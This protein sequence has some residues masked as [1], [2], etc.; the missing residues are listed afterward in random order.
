MP[1]LTGRVDPGNDPSYGWVNRRRARHHRN[2][3]LRCP[4]LRVCGPARTD[5]GCHR[6]VV[7]RDNRRLFAR[8]ARLRRRGSTD[9][10]APRPSQPRLLMTSGSIL[11]AA[12]MLAWSH[13]STLLELYLVFAGLGVAMALVLYEPAF[14]VITRWFQVRRNA[15]LTTLT[16]IAAFASFIFSPLTG[17]L[18]A[19][20]GWRD[21]VT[22]LAA[23]LAVL[24]IPLHAVVL[25]PAPQHDHLPAATPRGTHPPDRRAPRR[26]LAHRRRVRARLFRQ[27]R[28]RR[29]SGAAPH[30]RR[31][32]RGLRGPGR[33]VGPA[34]GAAR[35]TGRPR[36]HGAGRHVQSGGSQAVDLPRGLRPAAA[37]PLQQGLSSWP[38]RLLPPYLVP[39]G[40]TFRQ[41]GVP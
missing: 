37:V 15:A 20:Y 39:T 26:V 30:R 28:R 23:V 38:T 11:A 34:C 4:N 41:E 2:R 25:R 3:Q 14:V 29:P 40:A 24:T 9:R 13:V 8:A 17:R 36:D 16:L 6:L 18:V 27:R 7:G 21:A 31:Y 22:V 1:R 5:A 32:K 19:A 10:P 12:L 35:R 33:R